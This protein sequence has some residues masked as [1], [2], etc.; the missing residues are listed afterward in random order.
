[1][2][3]RLGFAVQQ[4]IDHP[5]TPRAQERSSRRAVDL[6]HEHGGLDGAGPPEIARPEGMI[7]S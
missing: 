3:G 4:S 1:V 5:T 6:G 7:G 2:G